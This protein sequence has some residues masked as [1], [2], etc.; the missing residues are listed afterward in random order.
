MIIQRD[1][2]EKIKPFLKRREFISIIGPGNQAK[3]HFWKY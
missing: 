2:I 1:L 3:L